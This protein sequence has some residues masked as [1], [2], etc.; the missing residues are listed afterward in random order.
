MTIASVDD[1][2][3]VL[4]LRGELHADTLRMLETRFADPRLREARAWV[5]ELHELTHID[6]A[7]AYALLRAL[8]RRPDGT[9]LTLRGARRHVARTLRHAGID[10]VGAIEA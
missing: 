1:C 6:L 4:T 7:C 5:L 10:A 2:R 3:V 8:S 9:A